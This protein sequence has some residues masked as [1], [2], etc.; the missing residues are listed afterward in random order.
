MKYTSKEIERNGWYT[1]IVMAVPHS[2]GVPSGEDWGRR[3]RIAAER[4]RWTD[5]LTDELFDC[6]DCGAQMVVGCVS[7]FD[8]DLE[9][10]EGEHD[11]LCKYTQVGGSGIK[12]ARSFSNRMLAEWYRYRAEVLECAAMGERPLIIDCHSFPEDLARDVDI[13]IGF[14][15]DESCPTREVLDA[16]AGCFSEAGYSV[17]FNHPYSNALAPV[18]YLGHSLMIEVNKHCYLDAGQ[19]CKGA[20]FERL[21]ACICTI[22]SRMLA[23]QDVG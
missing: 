6:R 8:C 2:V 7:R 9:R 12:A 11:R 18:G 19:V 10:L 3:G 16:V 15:E 5:W 13:C 4:D 22:V 23:G 1:N 17:K 14:N 21:H 20:G